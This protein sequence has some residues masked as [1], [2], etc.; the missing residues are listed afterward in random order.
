M[1]RVEKLDEGLGVGLRPR[2]S[3][4]QEKKH[5]FVAVTDKDDELF[6]SFVV[7]FVDGNQSVFWM[8]KG[9]DQTRILLDEG[10]NFDWVQFDGERLW[11]SD[12]HSFTHDVVGRCPRKPGLRLSRHCCVFRRHASCIRVSPRHVKGW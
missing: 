7:S 2:F 11:F 8:D 1:R 5:G 3:F 12:E 9:A 6:V 10:S 4:V